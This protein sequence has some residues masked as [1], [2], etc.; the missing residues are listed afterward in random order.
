MVIKPVINEYKA[1]DIS[2]TVEGIDISLSIALE[3]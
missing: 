1:W 3:N 2:L